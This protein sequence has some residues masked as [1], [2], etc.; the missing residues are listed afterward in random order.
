MTSVCHAQTAAAAA[1][2]ASPGRRRD[3]KY[4]PS[5]RFGRIRSRACVH[6]IEIIIFKSYR[7]RRRGV[8]RVTRLCLL[9]KQDESAHI[10]NPRGIDNKWYVVLFFF[11]FT[12][13][14]VSFR[15]RE[16]NCTRHRVV[17]VFNSKPIRRA[18]D[19]NRGRIIV[20]IIT[21][22]REQ[23]F[24]S[25]IAV[26]THPWLLKLIMMYILTSVLFFDYVHHAV[27]HIMYLCKEFVRIV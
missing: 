7:R 3:E 1:A 25:V 6:G 18:F 9:V 21:L 13:R 4:Y 24:D 19:L 27:V 10:G 16:N 14:V 22:F 17:V 11:I 20:I 15:R 5:P 12:R 26:Q 2:A 23:R 8:A